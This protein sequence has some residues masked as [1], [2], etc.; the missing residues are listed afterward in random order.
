MS[1]YQAYRPTVLFRSAIGGGES[2]NWPV[3]VNLYGPDLVR[4]SG[5]A[6]QL[7]ERLHAL[8]ELIDIKAR[9]NLGNPEIRVAVDRQR[10]ADLG[11]RVADLAGSLRLMVSGE[12]EIT[13]YREG[14]ERYPVKMRVREDQRNDVGAVGGLMVASHSGEL[15]RIDNVAR[16]ERGEGPTSITRLDRQ[17]SVGVSADLRPG[18]RARHHASE[19]PGRSS[20]AQAAGRLPESICRAGA[21]SWTRPRPT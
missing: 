14:G 6:V 20:G 18:Q 9:V 3:L 4:L 7:N 16:L 15:V 17:F 11:V 21:R 5:Y 10:A 8:P 19:G 12:D 2:T 13:S 1:A